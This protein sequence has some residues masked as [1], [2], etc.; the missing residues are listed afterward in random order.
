VTGSDPGLGALAANGGPTSTLAVFPG[1]PLVDAGD[2]DGCTDRQGVV[3]AFDQRGFPR[4]RGAGCDQGAFESDP[5]VVCASAP[6]STA[7][8]TPLTV[9]LACTDPEGQAV[10]YG[11]ASAQRATVTGAGAARTYAPVRD[12]HGPDTI[13]FSASDGVNPPVFASL[14]VTV[15]PVN[16]APVAAADTGTA[17]VVAAPGV[18]ANDTDV[19]RD[20]LTA[21][22]VT[23]PANGTVTLNPD[24]GYVYTPAAGFSGT[25]TFTYVAR[26]AASSSA[27]ATVTITVAAPAPS[28]APPASVQPAT[29]PVVSGVR[30]ARR[31]RAVRV[32]LSEPARVT[33]RLLQERRGVRRGSRCVAPT[34]PGRRC[35][36]RVRVRSFTRSAQAGANTFTLPRVRRGRY[37]VE[38]RATDSGGLRSPALSRRLT[39]G[40]VQGS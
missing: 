37:I 14:A 22:L 30:A 24:G 18:L 19:D 13:L 21:Q 1:S 6:V 3:L 7:E 20:A 8:D 23:A 11:V 40:P 32:T 38:V 25:D 39:L 10:T 17:G 36:R 31:G 26:D 34:R 5:A 33:V 2:P 9:T 35:V 12:Y 27:P 29:A 4:N 28:F 15:T 16:D